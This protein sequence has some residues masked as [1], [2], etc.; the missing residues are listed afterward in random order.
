MSERLSSAVLSGLPA[1]VAVPRYDRSLVT[2]GIVHLGLGAFHRAHQAVFID[3]CLGR[4]E[5]EWGIVAASLRHPHTRDAIAPQDNL[6][7]VC[8]REGQNESLRVV[9]SI[10]E[11]IVAPENPERLLDVLSDALVRIV[12]LTVTEKGYLAN[13]ASRTLLLAHPDIVH[14]LAHPSRPRS[15]YGFLLEATRRRRRAGAVPLTLLSCDNLPSNGRTL[16]R[17]LVEFADLTDETLGAYVESE[18]A[19]PCTMVDRIV[20]ATSDEDR[21]TITQTLGVTDAWP[22]VAE[23]YFRWVIEDK[24]AHGRPSLEFSGAEF[25]ADVEPFEHMKLR[26]LNGAHTAIAAIGQIAGLETVAEAFADPRVRHYVNLYWK[27]AVTAVDPI[28]GA[29]NYVE[30]LRGRFA[31]PALRHRTLQIASDASQKLPQRILAPL[32]EILSQGGDARAL[33]FA[34]ALWIQSC[35]RLNERGQPITI[36]DPAFHQWDAPDQCSFGAPVIVDRF[37]GFEVVF[38]SVWRRQAGFAVAVTAALHEI[39]RYGALEA[40]GRLAG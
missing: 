30:G 13:L 3:D 10:L 11:T 4:G 12:T 18:V 17:L 16:Q 35:A 39:R 34:V 32:G 36:H 24:F 20:P 8:L 29:A 23:P 28:V 22:V 33:I 25:V 2:P 19:C 1:D 37:I 7:T 31:N 26:L 40:I 9:G 6:Y 38:G 15:I 21:T 14:D 27:Q 5:S